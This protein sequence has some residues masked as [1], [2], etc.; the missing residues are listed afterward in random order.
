MM[1]QPGHWLLAMCFV[2]PRR[3]A[4]ETRGRRREEA[5]ELIVYEREAT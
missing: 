5:V 1:R 2:R 3:L 4:A